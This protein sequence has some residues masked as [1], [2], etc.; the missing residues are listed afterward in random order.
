MKVLKTG[1][2]I[3]FVCEGCGCINK[4]IEDVFSFNGIEMC[5]ECVDTYEFISTNEYGMVAVPK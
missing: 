1:D 2:L 4:D 5:E 3:E